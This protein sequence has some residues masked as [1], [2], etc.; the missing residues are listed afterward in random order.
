MMSLPYQNRIV[1]PLEFV[2]VYTTIIDRDYTLYI[3]V[4]LSPRLSSTR[5]PH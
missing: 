2:R 4:L 5:H 1:I 3:M